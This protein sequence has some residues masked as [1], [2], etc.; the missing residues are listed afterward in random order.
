M[1]AEQYYRSELEKERRLESRHR[2]REIW[3][4]NMLEN[5]KERTQEQLEDALRLEIIDG[6]RISPKAFELLIKERLADAMCG[7]RESLEEH[8][9]EVAEEGEEE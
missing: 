7:I 4:E 9:D 8:W 3:V 2:D 1:N 5:I 6:R